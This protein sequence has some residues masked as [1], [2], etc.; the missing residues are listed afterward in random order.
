MP[1]RARHAPHTVV[2]QALPVFWREGYR[3]TSIDSLVAATQASRQAIYGTFGDKH[4]LLLAC[5]ERYRI[6]IV[7]PAV[8]PM[9]RERANVASISCYF[10]RQ[11]SAAEAAGFPSSGCFLGNLATEAAPHNADVMAAV[12]AHLARLTA[13]FANA[14]RGEASDREQCEIDGWA[15]LLTTTAQGL[16][17]TARIV[18]DAASL[19]RPVDALLELIQGALS[20]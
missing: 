10:E 14:L 7:D 11:I 2:Q 1:R 9:E 5:I 15:C 4:A 20:R 3:A 6:D 12:E 13:A 19:R 8:V 16:W 18:R 17:S